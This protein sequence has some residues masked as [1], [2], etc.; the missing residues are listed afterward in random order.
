MSVKF[1]LKYSC[2]RKTNLVENISSYRKYKSKTNQKENTSHSFMDKTLTYMSAYSKCWGHCKVGL[3]GG[4]LSERCK[5]QD[6]P[7][8]KKMSSLG[9]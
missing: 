3:T 7:E 8:E 5:G 9:T 2:K 1:G 6:K 4:E